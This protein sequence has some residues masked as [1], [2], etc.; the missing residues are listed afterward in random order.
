MLT[1]VG[2]KLGCGGNGEVYSVAVESAG[3]SLSAGNDFVVKILVVN[4][5]DE[6]ELK[7]RKD[8]F[9]KEIT[10]VIRFQEKVTGIIP[11]YD[12]S[13]LTCSDSDILWYIMPFA[14]RY[15]PKHYSVSQ[16]LEQMLKLG[17]CIKQI[18]DLGFAHRDIKP[19]NL[20][21]WNNSICLSDFGLVWN[22]DSDEEHITEVND[23]LGPQ[24]IRP[25]ELQPVEKI[26]GVDYRL[27]DIY[28]FAKTV[29]MVLN[30]NNHGFPREY[31]RKDNSV[32]IDCNKFGLETAE[33][34]H[35][36]LEGATKDNYWERITL[37][38]CLAHIEDQL[39]VAKG[40]SKDSML[41]AW[42]YDENAKW[43]NESLQYDEKIYTKSEN[44]LQI[45]TSMANTAGLVFVE[46][47]KEYG[48]CKL[49]KARIIQ[50]NLYEIEIINPYLAGRKKVI[51][52]YVENIHLK[53]DYSYELN[54]CDHVRSDNN[55]PV[56]KSVY[57]AL[58]NPYEKVCLNSKCLIKI[59]KL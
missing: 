51:E 54:T 14:E 13:I 42:K 40:E 48:V 58:T 27:S 31:S 32:Y 3:D 11:I 21:L 8:R 23:R 37:S 10:E 43:I 46:L 6:K 59:E 4:S 45:L 50:Q 25:P 34:L 7:K 17:N 30:C 44:I 5:C 49:R 1:L 47:G 26:D 18:H 36:M 28:L 20:L 56:V 24:A 9:K 39:A 52:I 55:V 53:K 22:I 33:P 2:N 12:A 41:S 35:Q 29:W 19:R 38:Q 16:R 15:V 57:G